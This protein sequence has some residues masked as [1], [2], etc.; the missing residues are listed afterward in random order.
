LRDVDIGG[1]LA[2][3]G[4]GAVEGIEAVRVAASQGVVA[5][6]VWRSYGFKPHRIE[7]Y[8]TSN[9]PDF[10]K[11][12]AAAIGMYLNPQAHAAVF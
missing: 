8:M 3:V 5:A 2:V 12:A 1:K 11:K 4:A 10:A 6:R 9:D 7:R